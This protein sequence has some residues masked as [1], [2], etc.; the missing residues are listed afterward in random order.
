M[1]IVE[2]NSIDVE[3]WDRL[4]LSSAEHTLFSLSTYLDAVAENW[5]IL[6]DD[7]YSKGIALPYSIRLGVKTLYVPF[8]YRYVEVLG[9]EIVGL[10]QELKKN[11]KV[12][13][14]NIKTKLNQFESEILNYQEVNGLKLNQ[15]AKRMCSKAL[16]SNIEIKETSTD[17]SSV[18]K[19][20]EDE[21][22]QKVT[23]FQSDSKKGIERLIENL[24]STNHLK[25]YGFYEVDELVGGMIFMKTESR[26]IYLKGAAKEN[27]RNQGL[28]YACM[29]SE[30]EDTL[31]NNKVFDFGGSSVEGVRRFNLNF[32]AIDVNYFH[33][34]WNNGPIWWKTIKYLRNLWKK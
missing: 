29:K 14:F 12:S 19:I 1:K 11:F 24:G 5:A 17:F 8:F 22:K 9:G 33:Y 2:R 28:M 34:E 18:L 6:I 31:N 7:T 4:V 23:V 13:N 21:L 10:E 32:G 25:V 30:I 16:K 20:I 26:T 15:Q 3:K 27:A